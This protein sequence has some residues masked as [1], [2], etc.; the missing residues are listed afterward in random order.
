M[1]YTVCM[2][3]AVYKLY[4]GVVRC[5]RNITIE[6]NILCVWTHSAILHLTLHVLTKTVY[7]L[8]AYNMLQRT[9]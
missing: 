9:R 7:V 4:R 8:Y 1:L 2:K 6:Y 5:I 3:G